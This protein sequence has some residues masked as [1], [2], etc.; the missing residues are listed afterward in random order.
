MSNGPWLVQKENINVANK[1]VTLVPNPKYW[2]AQP[3]LVIVYTN[4][5][6]DSDTNV[7]G[8]CQNAAR[9]T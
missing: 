8:A 9:S 2:G 1:T 5:G 4:I 3:K 6:S 7:E